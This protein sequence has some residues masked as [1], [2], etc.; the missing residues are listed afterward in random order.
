MKPVYITDHHVISPLGYGS[1]VNFDALLEN[2]T[3]IA[4][5][6]MKNGTVFQA[7]L[8]DKKEVQKRFNEFKDASSYTL[9]EQMM[10]LSIRSLLDKSDFAITDRTGLIISTTKGNIDVLEP[11]SPFY[12]TPKRAYL[13]ELG[14]QIRDYFNFSGE[15]VVLSNA[16]VSGVMALSVASRLIRSGRFDDMVVV[17]GDLVTEFVLSGFFSFNAISNQACKPYSKNRSGITLG[18]AVSSAIVTALPEKN[19]FQIL[20]SGSKN[21]ANH[22]SG[23]SRTGEG[24]YLSVKSALE[25]SKLSPSDIDYI[26]AHGTA[27][28]YNDEMEAIAFNRLGMQQIPLNSLKAYYGHTLG[29]SGLLETLMGMEAVSNNMLVASLGFDE[30]GV[31]EPLKIIEK[32]VK[33]QLNIFLKTASGFGGTNTALILKQL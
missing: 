6:K 31:S 26:C 10:I 16:C 5:H 11:E 17:S 3:G 28:M 27:T 18:E 20:G 4:S 1:K 13:A 7:A 22:I 12:N 2:R 25:E 23:P 21:D 32:N 15:A 19:A 24:L 8:I 29:S 30:L 33:N 14:K 9:L